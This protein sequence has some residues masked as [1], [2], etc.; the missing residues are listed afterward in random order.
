MH[1]SSRPI[2]YDD[3]CTKNEGGSF[4]VTD[5]HPA[6]QEHNILTYLQQPF[7][8]IHV[9]LDFLPLLSAI[10]K[11]IQLRKTASLT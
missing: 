7:L 5:G 1:C 6:A 4:P 2:G 8:T 10:H 9:V 11:Y 3:W